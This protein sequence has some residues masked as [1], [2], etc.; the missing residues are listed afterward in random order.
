MAPEP[1]ELFSDP[2]IRIIGAPF[3]GALLLGIAIRLAGGSVGDVLSQAARQFSPGQPPVVIINGVRMPDPS[4]FLDLPPDARELFLLLWSRIPAADR[5]SGPPQ[6]PI[7]PITQSERFTAEIVY[8][9]G[10]NDHLIPFNQTT[11]RYGLENGL[12]PYVLHPAPGKQPQQLVLHDKVNQCSF[13]VVALTCNT[14]AL[15]AAEPSV[16]ESCAWHPAVGKI[17][18]PV[19]GGEK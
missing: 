15:I 8:A 2:L 5:W 9:D 14:E 19:F 17:Q 10:T 3:M 12:A 4:V 16:K 1:M 18:E 11:R 7:A 6:T 13:A